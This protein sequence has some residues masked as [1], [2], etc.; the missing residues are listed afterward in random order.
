LYR[1][2]SGR[3]LPNTEKVS[4]EVRDRYRSE[5]IVSSE[6]KTRNLDYNI[7]YQNGTLWFRGPIPVHDDQFNPVYIVIE[8]EGEAVGNNGYVVGG[9]VGY[10]PFEKTEIGSTAIKE[11]NTTLQGELVSIDVNQQLTENLKLKA[12]SGKSSNL[13]RGLQ[14]DG[15]ARIGELIYENATQ[16]TS[17]YARD[18][19]SDY[20]LGEQSST[21]TGMRKTGLDSKLS[22]TERTK[23]ETEI[24]RQL[25]IKTGSHRTLGQSKV[26]Y[27][28][29]NWSAYTGL[30]TASDVVQG[31]SFKANQL[32]LGG[33]LKPENSK[34]RFFNDTQLLLDAVQ[35]NSKDSKLGSKQISDFPN[36]TAVGAEYKLNEKIDLLAQQQ[37]S[38]GHYASTS[39]T[40]A[41]IRNKPWQ[42]AETTSTLQK[43]MSPDEG[44]RVFSTMG[45]LQN[46]TWGEGW[47]AAFSLDRKNTVAGQRSKVPA[48]QG[49]GEFHSPH[50]NS[51]VPDADGGETGEDYIAISSGL[52]YVAKKYEWTSRAE[53]RNAETQEIRNFD[54]GYHRDIATGLAQTLAVLYTHNLTTDTQKLL[55]SMDMRMSTGWRPADSDWVVLQRVDLIFEESV[56][57][58]FNTKTRKIVQNTNANY[59]PDMFNQYSFQYSSKYVDELLDSADYSGYIDFTGLEYRRFLGAKWDVGVQGAAL[60]AWDSGTW[61]NMAGISVGYSPVK[62]TWISVGYNF[63]GF[64]DEDFTNADATNRGL[65][66]KFRIKF[67]Q[68]SLRDLVKNF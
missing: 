23:L 12:E 56:D 31:N 6:F 19:G 63:M 42:G 39:T 45:L 58:V 44:G 8:Y 14:V 54:V 38:W 35:R 51:L 18:I 7:D 13:R 10:K 2:R 55:D 46:F 65:F 17:L 66:L 50:V 47:R 57:E 15:T 22:I 1:L 30:L 11:K 59:Q 20:G 32:L 24:Y 25:N 49:G 34:F 37:Y 43:E 3:I 53:F 9:R 64:R 4:I 68:D 67:D 27:Q 40:M 29:D 16:K 26:D 61:Q 5:V 52:G 41:G 28:K 33:T 21:E 60:H 62:N 48:S 36:L